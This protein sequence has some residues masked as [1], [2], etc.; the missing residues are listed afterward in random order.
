MGCIARRA[1]TKTFE[2]VGRYINV[3][4]MTG[5]PNFTV[6]PVALTAILQSQPAVDIRYSH[7]LPKN[8]NTMKLKP[9]F[10][11]PMKIWPF[12]AGVNL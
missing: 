3:P 2:D 12:S 7:R 11:G 1:V 6:G 5:A 9:I 4:S 8:S 10:Q